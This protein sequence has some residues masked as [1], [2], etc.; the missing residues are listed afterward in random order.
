MVV[1][2]SSFGAYVCLRKPA[3]LQCDER[4]LLPSKVEGDQQRLEIPTPITSHS[5]Y[6]LYAAKIAVR[7]LFVVENS[8]CSYVGRAISLRISL[9]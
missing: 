3:G 6:T 2:E 5:Q 1:S 8:S 9:P 7:W 4:L